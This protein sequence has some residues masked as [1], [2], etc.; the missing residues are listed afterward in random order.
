MSYPEIVATT[1]GGAHVVDS[2]SRVIEFAHWE[3]RE[4]GDKAFVIGGAELYAQALPIAGEVYMTRIMRAY[5]GDVRFPLWDPRLFDRVGCQWDYNHELKL[6]L[7]FFHYRR[8]E[9][10]PI[11]PRQQ[12]MFTL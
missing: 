7:G 3:H 1:L 5:N 8:K 12:E 9:H 6:S 2:L 4:E 11:D 10:Y